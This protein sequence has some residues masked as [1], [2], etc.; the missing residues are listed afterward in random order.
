MATPLPLL[1]HHIVIGD[2]LQRAAAGTAFRD[3]IQMARDVDL[4]AS[5]MWL[6]VAAKT[7]IQQKWKIF[8]MD[9]PR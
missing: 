7:S 4:A 3:V 8:F 1:E 5:R 2:E 6:S 9:T